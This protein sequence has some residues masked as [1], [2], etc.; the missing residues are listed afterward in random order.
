VF[1]LSSLHQLETFGEISS[2]SFHIHIMGYYD[3]EAFLSPSFHYHSSEFTRNHS[4]LGDEHSASLSS[5][6]A[7]LS[8]SFGYLISVTIQQLWGYCFPQVLNLEARGDLIPPTDGFLARSWMVCLSVAFP[9]LQTLVLSH[10]AHMFPD[11]FICGLILMTELHY[12]RKGSPT[13][14]PGPT[15]TLWLFFRTRF[16]FGGL[17]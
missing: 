14:S 1:L 2:L 3:R 13:H 5:I 9:H 8:T 7:T 10:F 15:Y 6:F 12:L 17:V 16:P 11:D 4:T